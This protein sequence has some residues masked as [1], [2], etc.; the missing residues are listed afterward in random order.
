[1][2]HHNMNVT[3]KIKKQNKVNGP[4]GWKPLLNAIVTALATRLNTL[5]QGEHYLRD[6]I[7][8]NAD[9]YDGQWKGIICKIKKQCKASYYQ[10]PG[11]TSTS[12]W[13]AAAIAKDLGYTVACHWL[14]WEGDRL[15]SAISPGPWSEQV[16]LWSTP[17][18][19]HKNS[20][21]STATR[22]GTPTSHGHYTTRHLHVKSH[23]HGH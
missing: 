11:P 19:R 21:F 15:Q 2:K 16:W 12:I 23:P 18:S 3:F 8:T 1:M 13:Y 6:K 7:Y 22:P 10:G 4:S 17:P 20:V 9:L 14:W 5:R